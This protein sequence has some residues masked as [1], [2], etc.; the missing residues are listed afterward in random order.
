MIFL[1]KKEINTYREDEHDLLM[2]IRSGEYLDKNR[3]PIDEFYELVNELEGRLNYDK[4]NTNLPEAVDA[5]RIEDFV[6]DVNYSIV[7]GTN[8]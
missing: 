8:K 4:D 2:S 5:K 1:K 7:K 3:Q 6:Y